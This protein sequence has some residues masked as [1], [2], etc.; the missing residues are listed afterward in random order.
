[1]VHVFMYNMYVCPITSPKREFQH[2]GSPIAS[3]LQPQDV[4]TR[5]WKII[6]TGI[7]EGAGEACWLCRGHS[8][9]PQILGLRLQGG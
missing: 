7:R 4:H 2:R 9:I 6:L 3:P 1:M 8:V 5:G